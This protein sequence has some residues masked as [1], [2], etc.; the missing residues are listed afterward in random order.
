MP[1]EMQVMLNSKSSAFNGFEA[2][3]SETVDNVESVHTLVAP[4]T[5]EQEMQVLPPPFQKS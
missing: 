4:V 1:M 3:W 2:S 5:D